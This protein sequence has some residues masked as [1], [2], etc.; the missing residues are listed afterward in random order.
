MCVLFCVCFFVVVAV[1]GLVFFV[2]L[3]FRRLKAVIRVRAAQGGG[4]SPSL[5]SAEHLKWAEDRGW[6]GAQQGQG[7]ASS[8]QGW[9]NQGVSPVTLLVINGT[10][11][12]ERKAENPSGPDTPHSSEPC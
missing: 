12:P 4:G 9:W 1:V 7:R 2:L 6:E 10:R 5:L 8:L 3:C 11:Y